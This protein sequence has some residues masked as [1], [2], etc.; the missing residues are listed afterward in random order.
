MIWSDSGPDR[1]VAGD[2]NDTVY[3]NNGTAVAT[4]DCGPGDDTIYINPEGVPGA[5]M[6]RRALENGD[7]R[8]CEHVIAQAPEVDPTKGES[9][10]SGS[11]KGTTLR[12]GDLNDNILGGPGADHLVGLGGD[13]VIWGNHLHDGPSYGTDHID[14]GA[15]NDTVYGSRGG[16]VIDGGDGDD[17]LQG[18]PKRNVILGGAGNDTIRLRGKGPNTVSAG[19]GDDTIAA[20]AQGKVRID[21]GPGNDSVV[22]GF[23]R[24]VTTVNCET[25]KRPYKTKRR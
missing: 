3:V 23:N 22:T 12:G 10:S 13:D 19:D 9:L 21:C 1:I 25:V 16:N 2:G 14:A 7:I 5:I 4:V 11:A 15:G 20:Y 8:N 6:N 24:N 17:F 18:G